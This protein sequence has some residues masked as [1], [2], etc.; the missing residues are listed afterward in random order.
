MAHPQKIESVSRPHKVL[1]YFRFITMV[2][3]EVKYTDVPED[4][5]A[6]D[7]YQWFLHRDGK[8]NIPLKFLRQ[9]GTQRFFDWGISVDTKEPAT[10]TLTAH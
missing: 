10:V 7:K 5:P 1:Y 6:G 4:A 2:L 8:K 3:F 9:E